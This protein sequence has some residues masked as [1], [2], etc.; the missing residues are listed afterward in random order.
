[1]YSNNIGGEEQFRA[2]RGDS[3]QGDQMPTRAQQRRQDRS[4]RNY[5]SDLPDLFN[6]GMGVE[7]KAEFEV[8]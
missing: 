4:H 2:N 8:G 1:M 5:Q 3:Q 6:D 7:P